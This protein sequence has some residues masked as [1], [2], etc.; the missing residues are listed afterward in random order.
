MLAPIRAS[1]H[2]FRVKVA[3]D[4]LRGDGCGH[5]A[6]LFADE[7]FHDRR[8]VCVRA[9]RAG[10]FADG[11]NLAGA[12][13]TFERAGKLVVHQRHFQTER[14]RLAMN[15]VASTDAWREFVLLG[16]PGDDGQKFFDVGDQNIR[17]LHHLHGETG[18][19]DVAAREAEVQP[20]RRAVV[21]LFGNGGGETDDVVVERPFQFFGAFGQS[22]HVGEAFFRAA[23]HLREIGLRHDALLDEGLAGEQFN[24]QP[25]A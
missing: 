11:D 10:K 8:Q 17:A 3:L 22:L 4:D 23:L 18:V 20:A 12:F 19:H 6:E 2:E 13:E 21:D 5:Q 25:D 14:C 1:I 16:A 24:P 15:T 9:D 7:I